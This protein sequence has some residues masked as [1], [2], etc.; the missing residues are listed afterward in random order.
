MGTVAP[1]R[2]D[3]HPPRAYPRS[4][5]PSCVGG[6]H[7]T[8]D[9]RNNTVTTALPPTESEGRPLMGSP[10]PPPRPA[11][12]GGHR[13]D[14]HEH[15]RAVS[16]PRCDPEGISTSIYGLSRPLAV[17][18][19]HRAGPTPAPP[20]RKI[21]PEFFFLTRLDAPRHPNPVGNPLV[22]SPLTRPTVTFCLLCTHR[23]CL[24]QGQPPRGG[25]L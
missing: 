21:A 8:E 17:V 7:P 1:A 15:P 13:G 11:W 14:Q 20:T 10:L 4:G 3:L 2:V 24:D 25:L 5:A 19:A 18:A 16:P 6:R 23:S 9:D 12:G 22:Y